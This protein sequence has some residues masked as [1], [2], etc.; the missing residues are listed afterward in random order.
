PESALAVES[1]LLAR[2]V[3][4]LRKERDAAGALRTL[5]EYSERFPQGTLANEARFARV[6][7]LLGQGNR[8]QALEMLEH[9]Q[10]EGL[11][12]TTELRLLKAELLAEAG[13]CREAVPIFDALLAPQQDG[14]LEERALFGRAGCRADLG[15]VAG[16]RLDLLRYLER[17]PSGRF[18][19]AARTALGL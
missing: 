16:S 10:L 8:A 7:A 3:E 9:A 5:E 1:R 11:P 13:R 4:Q 6:E 15:E 18:A 12:R 17:F 2:A 14:A 19:D